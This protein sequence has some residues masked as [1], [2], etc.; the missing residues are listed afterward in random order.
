MLKHACNQTNTFQFIWCNWVRLLIRELVHITA[1]GVLVM[2]SPNKSFWGIQS[3]SLVL[4]PRL[5]GGTPEN[6]RKEKKEVMMSYYSWA[7][8][9]ADYAVITCEH[10]NNVKVDNISWLV[11]SIWYSFHVCQICDNQMLTDILYLLPKYL[12]WNIICK[13]VFISTVL[14]LFC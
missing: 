11:T 7:Q 13:N 4:L 3:T 10:Q 8:R 2:Y 5:L 6:L 1:C 14:W 12:C 9:L